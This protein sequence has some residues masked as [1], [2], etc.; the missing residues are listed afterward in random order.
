MA[1]P[2]CHYCGC[3]DDGKE[4]HELRPYGPARKDETERQTALAFDAAEKA[5]GTGGIVVIGG[6]KGLRSV[7]A[8][9]MA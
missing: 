7:R 8:R 9:G 2:K 1:E 4:R 5:A 6:R 3:A